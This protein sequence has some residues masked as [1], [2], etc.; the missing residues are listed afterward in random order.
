[1]FVSGAKLTERVVEAYP[2]SYKKP[3]LAP[4]PIE[5]ERQKP[6]ESPAMYPVTRDKK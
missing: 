3:A 4:Q 2:D 6:T 5:P 1:M